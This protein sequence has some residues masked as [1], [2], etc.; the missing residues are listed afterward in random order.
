MS[1]FDALFLWRAEGVSAL[2]PEALA[3]ALTVESLRY[4]K[5]PEMFQDSVRAFR[6]L[7]TDH[8]ISAART[9]LSHALKPGVRENLVRKLTR[10]EQKKL[11]EKEYDDWTDAELLGMLTESYE[12]SA[13]PPCRV[14]GAELKV[15]SIGGGEP[16]RYACDGRLPDPNDPEKTIWAQGRSFVDDHYS[17][18]GYEDRRQGGD[19]RV[20]EL[21]ARFLRR[22]ASL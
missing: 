11:W 6:K 1:R 14:C 10:E 17:R 18:S 20:M 9:Y 22:K 3:D 12:P 15:Q 19:G 16:T 21:V 4:E 7:R 5:I 13:I 8:R 2:T